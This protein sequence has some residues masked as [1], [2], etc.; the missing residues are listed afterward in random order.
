MIR[1]KQETEAAASL[2]KKTLQDL[3]AVQSDLSAAQEDLQSKQ[4]LAESLKA[5]VA[6]SKQE[7]ST[8]QYALHALHAE[9]AIAQRAHADAQAQLS[10][11]QTELRGKQVQFLNLTQGQGTL[12]QSELD[13]QRIIPEL[14]GCMEGHHTMQLTEGVSPSRHQQQSWVLADGL[15]TVEQDQDLQVRPI[16]LCSRCLGVHMPGARRPLCLLWT[17]DAWLVLFLDVCYVIVACFGASRQNMCIKNSV[18]T[19][20]WV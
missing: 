14:A 7:L 11:V 16:T 5:D 9:M 18:K 8:L 19:H 3:T 10:H 2:K 17:S 15:S 1:L 13:G 12:S 6:V 20:P 4:T